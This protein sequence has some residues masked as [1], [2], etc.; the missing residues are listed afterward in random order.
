MK[1]FLKLIFG[2][3]FKILH[4]YW[5]NIWVVEW[6]FLRMFEVLSKLNKVNQKGNTIDFTFCFIS[7]GIW[8]LW[9]FKEIEIKVC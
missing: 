7:N 1:N 5:M 2:N 4:K 6:E 9:I 8:F 3:V